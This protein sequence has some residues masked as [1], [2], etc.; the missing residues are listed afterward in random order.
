M[1]RLCRLRLLQRVSIHAKDFKVY[2]LESWFKFQRLVCLSN[3]V[4]QVLVLSSDCRHLSLVFLID[5]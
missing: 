3:L 5:R 2:L 4:A 1:L